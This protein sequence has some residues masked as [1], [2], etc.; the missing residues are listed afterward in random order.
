MAEQEYQK[1]Q[2]SLVESLHDPSYCQ[3]KETY[4]KSS[5]SYLEQDRA[6]LLFLSVP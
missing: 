4:S 1:K 5:L 3:L 6:G 2:R